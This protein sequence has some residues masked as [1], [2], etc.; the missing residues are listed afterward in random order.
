[1]II[2]YESQSIFKLGISNSGSEYDTTPSEYG[3]IKSS[4]DF[5]LDQ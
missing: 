3:F 1:M 2:E 4:V 5:C